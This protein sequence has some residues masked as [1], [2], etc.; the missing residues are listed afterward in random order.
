M[1][2][3]RQYIPAAT[4]PLA[5]PTGRLHVRRLS[6]YDAQSAT[7]SAVSVALGNLALLSQSDRYQ[8]VYQDKQVRIYENLSVLPRAFLV[9]RVEHVQSEEQARQIVHAGLLPDGTL[10]DPTEVAL[11]EASIPLL[12]LGS[13]KDDSVGRPES[14]PRIEVAPGK[15]NQ[16][17]L[18]VSTEQ[19]ALLVY[20]LGHY[21][22]WQARVDGQPV[23]IYRTN[24]TLMGVPV[25]PGQHQIVL[26][27]RPS[28]LSLV[29]SSVLLFWFAEGA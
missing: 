4:A 16:I 27:Y 5:Q 8:Q 26:D 19:A 6:L 17:V 3:R 15:G 22:G 20:S 29:F 13:G 11:V 9:P 28:S 1:P 21:P 25:P 12:A 7:S 10:F 2:T 24:G 23:A 14:D 18:Q